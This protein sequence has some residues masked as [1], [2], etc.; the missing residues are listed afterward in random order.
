MQA[1][2]HQRQRACFGTS[3]S[4][5]GTALSGARAARQQQQQ[6]ARRAPLR[7]QVGGALCVFCP[8]HSAALADWFCC[9]A[10]NLLAACSQQ[11]D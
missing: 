11:P 3:S 10:T 9:A 2:G 6:R 8:R 1:L 5:S 4:G 7:V